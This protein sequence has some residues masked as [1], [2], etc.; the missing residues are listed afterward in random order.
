MSKNK[1]TATQTF[2]PHL[3]AVLTDNEA[4]RKANKR[5]VEASTVERRVP[6]RKK[7]STG[8]EN[9]PPTSSITTRLLG[10]NRQW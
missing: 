6:V 7:R 10:T 5:S 8:A 3:V 1:K 9:Q 2:D 4:A